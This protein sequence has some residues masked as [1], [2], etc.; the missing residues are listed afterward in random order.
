MSN[1]CVVHLQLMLY[2]NCNRQNLKTLKKRN[3]TL[4]PHFRLSELGFEFYNTEQHSKK[5]IVLFI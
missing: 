3:A 4:G 5:S 2:V 1:L